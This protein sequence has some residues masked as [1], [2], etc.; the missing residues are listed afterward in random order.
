MTEEQD[1]DLDICSLKQLMGT[2]LLPIEMTDHTIEF[3][4]HTCAKLGFQLGEQWHP[5]SRFRRASIP[6]G[7]TKQADPF[8]S[9]RFLIHDELGR[10][11]VS[12]T[13]IIG[14]FDRAARLIVVSPAGYVDWAL[15]HRSSIVLDDVWTTSERAL[16][17]IDQGISTAEDLLS[18]RENS[19]THQESVLCRQSQSLV[20]ECTNKKQEPWLPAPGRLP[21][22]G[23]A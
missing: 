1:P 3:G 12:V 9:S 21:P 13:L 5:D 10:P 7:W 4:P 11:R 2:D 23:R 16:A 17:A 19:P 6:P 22:R 8:S 18:R 14:E 20:A 15:T